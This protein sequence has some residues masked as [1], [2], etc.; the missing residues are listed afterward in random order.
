MAKDKSMKW[1]ELIKSKPT[2]GPKWEKLSQK[3]PLFPEVFNPLPSSV[4][5]M[6]EGKFVKLNSQNV[7]NK[8]N[9]S[10]EEAAYFYAKKL[11]SDDRLIKEKKKIA[12]TSIRRDSEFQKNFFE[13]W[14]I[15]LGS[16]TKIKSFEKVDF[17]IMIKYIKEENERKKI[18]KKSQSHESKMIEKM[19]KE[20]LKKVYGYA[21]FDN[22]SIPC[23]YYLQPPG[24]YLGHGK[25]V[26]RGKIKKRLKGP[27][28][29]LN[30]SKPYPICFNN[31][32]ECEWGNVVQEH[33]CTWLSRWNHPISGEATYLRL[34]RSS[35]PWVGKADYNK[36]EKAR[37]LDRKIGNIRKK[38]TSDLD[39][40][41]LTIQELALAVFFLD[42]IAIR[43]GSEG[44][45]SGTKGL[46]T[47]EC[48][49]I[50]INRNKVSIDF[51]G[52]SSID[53]NK[54]IVFP[55][56]ELKVLKKMCPKGAKKDKPLFS[57]VTCMT[58]N[59][60]LKQLL[61]GLT[62][63][64]FRTWRA[65]SY[66]NDELDKL[67]IKKEE[68]IHKKKIGFDK[69]N[70]LVAKSLNHKRMTDNAF[71]IEKT[72]N[73][74][75]E[76]KKEIDEARTEKQKQRKYIMLEKLENKLIEQEENLSLNTSKVN[77]MDPRI[78]VSWSKKIE[79]P[80]DKIMNKTV[81][82]NFIWSMD[83]KSIWKW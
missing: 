72:K 73:K 29:T 75:L 37:K 19:K 7:D 46:T 66:L 71:Q 81:R 78:I 31:G 6:Y 23:T 36:F 70:L 83:T 15:I 68:D 59:K 45:K 5:I 34:V 18:T 57:N 50:K 11:E 61:P 4:G 60:Y 14:K 58:L 8:F 62:A 43:P 69:A 33:D 3:G 80:I 41:D 48:S 9:V 56:K 65:S 64:V 77:Y 21:E 82:E 39:S 32:E 16:K 28:I 74:I 1:W 42:K 79:I 27:D 35:D 20:E 49:N 25:H 63:K 55:P 10:S 12:S 24:L 13:D 2:K 47:L 30:C 53:F 67:K 51:T 17:S 52:K 54:T 26:D 40:D 44:E 22:I 76:I 38:Y